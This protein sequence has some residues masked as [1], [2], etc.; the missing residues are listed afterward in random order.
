M[1]KY[2]EDTFIINQRTIFL[3]EN[4]TANQQASDLLIHYGKRK[5]RRSFGDW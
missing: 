3:G 2:N 5:A 4:Y 1:T